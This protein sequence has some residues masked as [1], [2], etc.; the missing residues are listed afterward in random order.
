MGC[1]PVVRRQNPQKEQ[2]ISTVTV[3]HP[4]YL[5]LPVNERKAG[6]V[7]GGDNHITHSHLQ[8]PTAPYR[9]RLHVP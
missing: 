3:T 2:Q 6:R 5:I 7:V 1:E 4:T 9:H 8:R